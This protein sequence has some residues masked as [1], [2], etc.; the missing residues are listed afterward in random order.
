MKNKRNRLINLFKIGV[1]LFGIPL[2]LWTCQDDASENISITHQ[3]KN[4]FKNQ[5][6][7]KLVSSQLDLGEDNFYV[8]WNTPVI[9][10]LSK[11]NQSGVYEYS[12]RLKDPILNNST[13]FVKEYTFKLIVEEKEN[14]VFTK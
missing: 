2:L 13:L 3:Q 10:D 11:K 9:L 7:T 14:D 4:K 6:N 12:I 5:F 1:L 8:D